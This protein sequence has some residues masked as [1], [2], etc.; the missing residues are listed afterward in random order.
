MS[1]DINKTILKYSNKK[2]SNQKQKRISYSRKY[3]ANNTA[4]FVTSRVEEGLPIVQS[5]IM[6]FI[7]WGIL[8]RA[9]TLFDI[10]ICHFVFLGNHFHM[11]LVVKNPDHLPAFVGYVKQE[12]AHAI[13]HLMGREKKTI[14]CDGYDSPVILDWRDIIRCIQ[15][16]YV[17]PVKA[18]LVKTIKDYPGV[19]SWSMYITNQLSKTC[20]YV[21]RIRVPKLVS[22]ALSICEQKRLVAFWNKV[23][24]LEN[25]FVLEPFAWVNCFPELKDI[26]VPRLNKMILSAINRQENKLELLRAKENKQ[27]IGATDLRRQSMDK[28]HIPNKR[29]KKTV[30]LCSNVSRKC[31]FINQFK[32]LCVIARDAF[33]DWKKGSVSTL[34]IPAG[35]F[36]PRLPTMLCAVAPMCLT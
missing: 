32:K 23:F 11:L 34:S 21:P 2:H 27:V 26:S 3:V 15:Y 31:G 10:S 5:F 6:N 12:T 1:T 36:A 29:G 4:V 25:E 19:S 22:F 35:L 20:I 17:N 18:N 28:H 24:K 8:A 13:N 14:W 16:I 7:I 9:K 33:E 30:C